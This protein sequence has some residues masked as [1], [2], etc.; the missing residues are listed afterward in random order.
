MKDLTLTL[1]PREALDVKFLLM[2]EHDRLYWLDVPN[3]DVRKRGRELAAKEMRI[4]KKV[5][6]AAKELN[7]ELG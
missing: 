7:Y 6:R 5:D 3:P 4:I 1:T 2:A